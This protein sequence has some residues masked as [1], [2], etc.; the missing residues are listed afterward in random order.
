MRVLRPDEMFPAGVAG[1][2][3]RYITTAA[4]LKIRVAEAGSAGGTPLLLL[5]GW[6][7]SLYAFRFLFSPLASMGYRVIAVDLKGHG[8]SD[9]PD[10]R[11]EYTLDSM[12]DHALQ[13]VAALGLASISVMG[14]SMGGRIVV[15]MALRSRALVKQI[16]LINPVGFGGM[17]HVSY[18]MPIANEVAARVFPS[19]MPS[20]LVRF[21]V[22]AVYG[23]TGSPTDRDVEEY[24]APTQF[25]PFIRASMHLLRV[26][27]W[28][29]MDAAR[30][31]PLRGR[32]RIV[33]GALDRV[34][35]TARS[36][37]DARLRDAGWDIDVVAD[38]A[39]VVHEEAP[40]AVMRMVRRDS[41]A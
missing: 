10:A 20:P 3:S 7:C 25:R 37:F 31:E 40:D 30:T 16:F 35:R 39:H 24:R 33:V 41:V 28:K 23:R 34:V 26:F 14:H 11:A 6:G 15:E 9:K 13:V 8:L 1:V 27:D 5:H 29:T 17:P 19:P 18:A 32:T 12:T 36:G 38:V 2:S 21:P 22:S 4:G